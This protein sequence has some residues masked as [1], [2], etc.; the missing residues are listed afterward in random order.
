[1]TS[2]RAIARLLIPLMLSLLAPLLNANALEITGIASFSEL[3]DEIY[4]AA[5]Y[6]EANDPAALFADSSERK[7]EIR[8]IDRMSKRRWATHWMQSIAINNDRDSLVNAVDELSQILSSFA[9]NLLPGDRVEIYFSP[10]LGTAIRIN[11]IT[12]ANGKSTQAFNLFLS[13]WIGPVPPSSQFKNILLGRD[14]SVVN[15]SAVNSERFAAIG[16]TP[17]RIAAVAAWTTGAIPSAA[18][19]P[20]ESDPGAP[21]DTAASDDPVVRTGATQRKSTAPAPQSPRLQRFE[22]SKKTGPDLSATTI[23]AQQEYSTDLI[24]TIYSKLQYPSVAVKRGQEGT[25]RASLRVAR[26]GSLRSMRLFNES[27]HNVLNR[28]A[29]RAIEATFPFAPI[30]PAIREVP[31]EIMVPITF[32]LEK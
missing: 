21:T 26:D 32:K 27:M 31:L 24:H 29:V 19:Q 17:S 3:G 14:S 8:F 11:G 12:L 30:P 28:E 22:E 5:L 20:A 16:P 7:M 1:M 25:V 9:D 13:S 10:D 15:S 6:S 18:S 23:L 2:G 4:L